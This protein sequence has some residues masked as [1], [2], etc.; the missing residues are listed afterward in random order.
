M[1]SNLKNQISWLIKSAISFLPWI[2]SIFIFYTLDYQIWTVDTPHRGKISVAI[3]AG[4]MILSLLV[5]SFFKK[6]KSKR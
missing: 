1:L 6:S 3:M 5:W 4:G 2:L